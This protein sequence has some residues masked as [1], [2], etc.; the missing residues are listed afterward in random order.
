M[1]E[2]AKPNR[3]AAGPDGKSVNQPISD[4]VCYH[5]EPGKHLVGGGQ[6]HQ[7]CHPAT[8]A[9]DTKMPPCLLSDQQHSV[10]DLDGVCRVALMVTPQCGSSAIDQAWEAIST[11]RVILKQQPVP[12]TV[13]MQTVFV[14]SAA[15]IGSFAS[16]FRPTMAI[17]CRRPVLSS[18]PRA[19]GRRWRS[20]RGPSVA[21]KWTCSFQR[22]M[23]SRSSTTAC[24]GFTSAGIRPPGGAASAYEE[25]HSRSKNLA[26]RLECGR[27]DL[28]R[29]SPHLAVP[30]RDYRA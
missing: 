15:D 16:C 21:T 12:M 3:E 5:M 28:Q 25:S 26:T 17:G 2:S 24:A 18:S 29:C 1:S 13:T 23:W 19:V 8:A 27:R 6:C 14:R 10:I 9:G 22:P 30:G 4:A 20:K 7:D 11:I